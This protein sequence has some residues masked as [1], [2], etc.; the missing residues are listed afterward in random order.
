MW[1]YFADSFSKTSNIFVNNANIFG[2]VYF[3]RLT[4]PISI[5]ISNLIKFGIQISLFVSIYIYYVITGKIEVLVNIYILL[6]PILIILMAI[7]GLGLGIIFSS[8]TTKYRDLGFLL[9]FGIQLLMYATPVIYPL[10]SIEGRFRK[11]LELNPL[12]SIIEN[13]RY[14]IFSQGQPDLGGLVYCAV[15]SVVVLFLG[16]I[17]FNQVEKSFMD[18]V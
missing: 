12:S 15:F 18:T 11:Y 7:L 17:I 6:L 1:T 4:T 9:T 2:K 10:S 16:I 8:L 14:A 5:I 3:P 13:F